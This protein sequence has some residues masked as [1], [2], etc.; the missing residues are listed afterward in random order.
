MKNINELIYLFFLQDEEALEMLIDHYRPM[1]RAIISTRIQSRKVDS[2]VI[3]EYLSW[4]DT[5]L[6][7][8]LYRYRFDIQKDFTSL[9]RC[10]F[11]NRSLDLTKRNARKSFSYYSTPISM[12]Q[13]VCE[14]ESI[15]IRDTIPAKKMDVPKITYS[16]IQ[17]QHIEEVLEKEFTKEEAQIFHF[18]K[19]GYSNKDIADMLHISASKVRYVLLKIKKWCISD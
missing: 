13:K 6:I 16:L 11:K 18:K 3:K 15:Y 9:Y 8:C 4:A 2:L 19:E 17:L 5:L 10:S 1:I 14:E 7:E 12:D